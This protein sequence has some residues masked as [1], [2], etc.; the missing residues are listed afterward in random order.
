VSLQIVVRVVVR[1]SSQHYYAIVSSPVCRA[2]ESSIA[3]AFPLALPALPILFHPS[4]LHPPNSFPNNPIHPLLHHTLALIACVKL[5]TTTNPSAANNPHHPPTSQTP[6]PTPP[7]CRRSRRPSRSSNPITVA[8]APR[9]AAAAPSRV[10]PKAPVASARPPLVCP[11]FLSMAVARGST[12]LEALHA[13]PL[14]AS[15]SLWTNREAQSPP[16]TAPTVILWTA[17]TGLPL[18]ATALVPLT[19]R[20][21]F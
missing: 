11:D 19:V 20:W 5:A 14:T 7:P 13:A 12:R 21:V 16:S 3:T 6:I 1:C 4:V 17:G 15:A 18:T 10:M 8:P 2:K 9:T